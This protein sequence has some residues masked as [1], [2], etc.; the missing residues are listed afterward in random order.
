MTEFGRSFGWGNLLTKSLA[1]RMAA[2]Y[3]R[4]TGVGPSV[5]QGLRLP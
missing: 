5:A 3:S 4:V 1:G 2:W